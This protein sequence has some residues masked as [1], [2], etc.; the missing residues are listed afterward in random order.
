MKLRVDD[1]YKNYG[2]VQALTGVTLEFGAGVYGL[3]GPNGAGKSTLIQV[4]TGNL[5]ATKGKIFYNGKDIIKEGKSYKKVLGYVPQ[6]QG[7]YDM[8][9]AKK[10]LEYMAILKDVDKKK[11]QIQI[12]EVLHVVG[13]TEVMNQKLGEFS[14]GM[15]QRILIGQALLGNPEILILDEPTAGLDPKERIKIRNFISKIAENK[16]VLI[17]THVVS[18]IETIAKETILLDKGKIVCQGEP[19]ELCQM[20]NGMVWECIVQSK[21]Y[22]IL[23][24]NVIISNL[25][26]NSGGMLSV[27]FI[28][29]REVAEK[30]MNSGIG[31]KKVFPNLQE[32]Y[33]Y[34]FT[35]SR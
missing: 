2:N 34:T 18:D 12:E 5:Q 1:I 33:L 25:Q 17:A 21:Q 31:I 22:D 16:I 6:S 32:I 35:E 4:I 9:T 30:L 24:R 26:E 11:I 28:C 8:F 15:K 13:L 20:L 27:R 7:I 23:N 3:L 19:K 14:G 29:E 10:F